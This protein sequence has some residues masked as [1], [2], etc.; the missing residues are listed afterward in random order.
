M[1][2]LVGKSLESAFLLKNILTLMSNI[3]N[4][5]NVRGA[6]EPTERIL[7]AGEKKGG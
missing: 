7:I 4:I 6:P 3:D 5:V 1:D 2:G